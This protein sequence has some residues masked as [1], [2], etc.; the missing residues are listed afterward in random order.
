MLIRWRKPYGSVKDSGIWNWRQGRVRM[1]SV[2][3][4]L[5]YSLVSV[6]GANVAFAS[7]LTLYQTLH[8]GLKTIESP[9]VGPFRV[10]STMFLTYFVVSMGLSVVGWILAI[11][12]VIL[13]KRVDEWRFW[14]Y[15]GIGIIFG[16]FALK[17]VSAY[18]YLSS[19]NRGMYPSFSVPDIFAA[20][21]S[22][23]TTMIFL[24]L[25]RR[26]NQRTGEPQL[27]LGL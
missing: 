19:K 7:I 2:W 20:I 6:L 11:P 23:L 17:V 18:A 25:M 3:R 5:M 1:V 8:V 12:L 9:G 26:A 16:P 24:L 13:A 21:V 14:M 22:S 15:L 4:R 10:F 27:P